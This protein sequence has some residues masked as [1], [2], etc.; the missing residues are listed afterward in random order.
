MAIT[1]F[2]RS[3]RVESSSESAYA[4]VVL[5]SPIN[6]KRKNQYQHTHTHIH[7]LMLEHTG[8]GERTDL[9]D[10]V[11]LGLLEMIV[12]TARM[13]RT[14]GVH[15]SSG[16]LAGVLER[17]STPGSPEDKIMKPKVPERE[18]IETVQN[19]IMNSDAEVKSDEEEEKE[20]YV[21]TQKNEQ[22]EDKFE[23]DKEESNSS[24][25]TSVVENVTE[26]PFG[27]G[28][29]KDIFKKKKRRN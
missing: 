2:R 17:M 13:D 1:L 15:R 7:T 18:D 16:A 14:K 9:I 27:W 3:E 24:S 23:K 25:N 6:S 28:S 12:P 11:I 26:K 8:T 29:M 19:Q 22:E 10:P 4:Y 20:D 21:G 5:R